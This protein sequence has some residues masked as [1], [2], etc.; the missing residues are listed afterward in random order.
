MDNAIKEMKHQKYN[1]EPVYYCAHCLSLKILNIA[2][3]GFCDDCG[4]MDILKDNIEVWNNKYI[5][6]YNEQ[7]LNK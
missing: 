1:D 7:Y 2:D 6:K 3:E 5:E 4:S